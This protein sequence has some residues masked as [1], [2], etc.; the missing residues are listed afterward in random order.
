MFTGIITDIGTIRRFELSSDLSADALLEVSTR[1]DITHI[2]NGDSIAHNGICLTVIARG[3]DE[4]G[5]WFATQLSAETLR[6]TTARQ[7]HVGQHINL[8]QALKVG[9]ALG[10]HMVLGHVDCTLALKAMH[11]LDKSHCCVFEMN[12]ITAPFVTEKGSITIDGVSLTVN[13][14]DDE[15]QTFSVNIVPHTW[16]HTVFSEYQ[17]GSEVNIEIDALARYTQR[18]LQTTFKHSNNHGE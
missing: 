14:V 11:V 13:A 4:K 17:P 12:R 16:Q 18:L 10:G 7:W 6:C 2:E 3:E 15:K 5:R 9:D 8:E 1:Y